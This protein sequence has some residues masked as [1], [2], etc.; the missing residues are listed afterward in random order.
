MK[1]I[2]PTVSQN[3]RCRSDDLPR[4]MR[5]AKFTTIGIE[6]SVSSAVD[7]CERKRE[8]HIAPPEVSQK[9]RGGATWT[10]CKNDKPTFSSAGQATSS[11]IMNAMVGSAS[12]WTVSAVKKA[13]GCRTTRMKSVKVSDKPTPN[14]TSAKTEPTERSTKKAGLKGKRFFSVQ[15]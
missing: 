12:I 5:R 14:I 9:T 7:R 13:R 11:A 6:N 2:W 10:G 4:K 8:R 15:K 3:G 1:K